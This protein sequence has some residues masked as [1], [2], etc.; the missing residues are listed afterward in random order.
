MQH[1]RDSALLRS[2]HSAGVDVTA[3]YLPSPADGADLVG[4]FE[5]IS[6]PLQQGKNMLLTSIDG[7]TASG[8]RAKDTD[9]IT[10]T[11]EPDR[12][13]PSNSLENHP[14]PEPVP[15]P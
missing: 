12:L 5:L 13:E 7:L 6:S 11:V 9:R 15:L 1:R 4:V 14:E 10:F 3:A 8:Q 2:V